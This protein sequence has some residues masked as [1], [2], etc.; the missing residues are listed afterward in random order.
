M[1]RRL[2]AKD[3]ASLKGRRGD[4]CGRPLF[5]GTAPPPLARERHLPAALEL[6]LGH[7]ICGF[8]SGP[9]SAPI[10]P[11]CVYP[12]SCPRRSFPPAFP[13]CRHDAPAT[14]R[15][16][17]WSV[18]PC[19]KPNNYRVQ[20]RKTDVTKPVITTLTNTSA[21]SEEKPMANE[22]AISSNLKGALRPAVAG[23]SAL[24]FC[25]QEFPLE[26][27]LFFAAYPKRQNK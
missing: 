4:R 15:R 22:R 23:I 10:A 14:L 18:W 12:L 9:S 2:K 5:G 20:F 11:S 3:G 26:Q 17:V 25:S 21:L 7:L 13:R 8:T 6:V 1:R 24:R 16:A 27:M 19:S